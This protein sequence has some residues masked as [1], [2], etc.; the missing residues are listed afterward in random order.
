MSVNEI[1]SSNGRMTLIS[2]T[3]PAKGNRS[4]ILPGGALRM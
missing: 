2:Q 1:E 4:L 3:V